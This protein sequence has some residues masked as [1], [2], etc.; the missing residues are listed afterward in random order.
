MRNLLLLVACVGLGAGIGAGWGSGRERP[1][2]DAGRITFFDAAAN[3][4]CDAYDFVASGLACPTEVGCSATL[5]A[6]P[7]GPARSIV[8]PCTANGCIVS[9]D[10]EAVCAASALAAVYA[11]A[12]ES[13]PRDAG[14]PDAGGVR[15]GCV[16]RTCADVGAQCGSIDDGCG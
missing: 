11:C 2:E 6:C 16:P 7:V 4:A 12:P 3:P 5:C 15:D 8:P 1:E 13:D 9:V 14:P 10:C